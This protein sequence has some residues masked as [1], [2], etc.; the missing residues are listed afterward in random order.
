MDKERVIQQIVTAMV[1]L[2]ECSDQDIESTMKFLR[3]MSDDAL[4]DIWDKHMKALEKRTPA[5]NQALIK[6]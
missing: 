2:E 5:L 3:W 1:T 6:K 4:Q